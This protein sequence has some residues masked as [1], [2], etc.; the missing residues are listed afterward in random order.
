MAADAWYRI[1]RSV[2]SAEI[3]DR[4]SRFLALVEP[5]ASASE[6]A[7][8]RRELAREYRGATHLCWAE[9]IGWPA[10]ERRSDAGEPA[11]TAGEPILRLLRG[12]ELSDVLAVV[13]RCYGGVKLGKGGLARAY[14]G[15]V[16]AALDGAAIGRRYPEVELALEIPYGKLGAVQNLLRPG[17]VAWTA[18]S[19]DAAVAGVLTVRSDLEASV[20][21][22]LEQIAVVP[23]KT[24]QQGS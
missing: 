14:A 21:A 7:A 13:V 8:R 24:G 6:A 4:G 3:K 16:G 1:L 15:V 5:V 17:R 18:T 22:A 10:E 23:V 9:R 12:W 20:R 11:G 2:A 19:Y